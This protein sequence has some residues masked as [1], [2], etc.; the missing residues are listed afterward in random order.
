[1]QM[2][3]SSYP[4]LVCVVCTFLLAAPGLAQTHN[5]ESLRKYLGPNDGMVVSGPDKKIVF[6]GI[7]FETTAPTVAAA[8]LLA[9]NQGVQN[10]LVFSAGFIT[11]SFSLA[12]AGFTVQAIGCPCS[13]LSKQ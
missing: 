4:A 12:A 3:R 8:L 10:F 6:L 1:M 11:S 5:F 13:S 7:G 2:K 9:K